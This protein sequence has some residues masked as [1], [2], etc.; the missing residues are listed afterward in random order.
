MSQLPDHEPEC[1]Q[2]QTP[3]VD[4]AIEAR[5]RDLGGFSVRRVLPAM[6]RRLVGPFIFFDH[7]G[8]VQFAPGDGI[9]V[10][11][12]PHIGLATVTYLFEG[13]ILHR[14]SLGSE[15]AIR[16]GDVNWMVAGSGIAHSERMSE[17]IRASGS[18]LHGIQSWIALPTEHEE[19]APTFEH[20]PARTLPILQRPGVTLH[21]IAGTAYG[22]TAPTR[23]LSPTIYVHARFEAGAELA[24]DEEHEQRAIYAVTGS[25]QCDGRDLHEGTMLVLHP[26]AH[27]TVR[28][29]TAGDVMIVGGAPIDG[30]RHIFWNFVSSSKERI[31]R[32]KADWRERRFPL[33]PGDDREFIPLPEA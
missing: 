31:E 11:P 16:P 27:A 21:V 4:L 15:Q 14:D 10:R 25:F 2:V 8:P 29:K 17:A 22:Q 28:A 13:E 19:S 5:A 24:I 3:S 7:M 26:R 18:K 32:A 30:P 6:Q 23:V 9:T 20:H 1:T 33:I 12:H